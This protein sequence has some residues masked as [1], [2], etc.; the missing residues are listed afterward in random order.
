MKMD[1]KSFGPIDVDESNVIS[2]NSG[3]PGFPDDKRFIL[4]FDKDDDKEAATFCWLQSI[5]NGDTAFAMLNPLGTLK[6]YKPIVSR[7]E[8]GELED[9]KEEDLL[10]YNIV[11]I[12]D[13]PAKTTVNLKA[14]VLIDANRKLGKQVVANNEEYTLRHFIVDELKNE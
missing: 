3:L 6:N 10:M 13:D 8:L 14:P 2:F 1:T 5:D 7:G 11:V 9:S 12:P 4:I